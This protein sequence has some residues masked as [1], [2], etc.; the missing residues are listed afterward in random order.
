MPAISALTDPTITTYVNRQKL[1]HT[2]LNADLVA[3]RSGIVDVNDVLADLQKNFAG[4]SAPTDN[5]V[6]GGLW[7]DT[8]NNPLDL[9]LD[10]D[11]SGADHIILTHIEKGSVWPS[12]SVHNNG[13]EQS[14]ITI[15]GGALSWSTEL[16]DT[17]SNFA[18][19]TFSP[20]VVGRY[21]LTVALSFTAASNDADKFFIQIFKNGAEY[22]SVIERSQGNQESFNFCIVVDND[23]NDTFDIRAEN[24][25][26]TSRGDLEGTATDTW[27]MGSRIA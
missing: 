22:K 23:G 18:S 17:N 12:F 10:P 14:N 3:L 24:N 11:G 20:T 27:F 13:V 9:K 7:A 8:T 16:F 25:T 26:D 1:T 15:A 21:L 5:T 4:A 6:E 2:L 19:D